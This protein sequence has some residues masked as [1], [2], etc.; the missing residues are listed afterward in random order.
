MVDLW[1]GDYSHEIKRHLLLQRRAMTN[2]GSVLK[3]RHITLPTNICVIKAMVFPVWLWE[4]DQK[5]SWAPKN[6]CFWTVVW[7]KTLESPCNRKEIKPVHPKGNQSWIFIW[8]TDANT[9]APILWPLHA[10]SQL[11][12]KDP[13]AWKDWRQEEKGTTEDEMVGWHHQLNRHEY[14]QTLGDGEN[15]SLGCWIP[16][17]CQKLDTTEG[18]NN[19]I[20]T[21]LSLISVHQCTLK[22][23]Q[24][25][26]SKDG[27]GNGTPLQYSCLENP[28]DRGACRLQSMGWL[29]VRHDRATSLSLFMHWSRQWQPTPFLARESQGR[30]S[31]VGCRL[32]GRTESDTTE[33]T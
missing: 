21:G 33:A 12:G 26:R 30:G 18:L 23:F 1:H 8:R 10:K 20:A 19:T 29:G 24:E 16:W 6:R 27:E 9:E 22:V 11:I 17:G 14:E 28:M 32:W 31:L 13:N 3:R 15:E 4:L 7:E 25:L 5:E 2:V